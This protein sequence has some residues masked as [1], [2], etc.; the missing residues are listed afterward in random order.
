MEKKYTLA[1]LKKM[2][3]SFFLNFIDKIKENLKKDK[4]MKK[5]F[6]DYGVDLAELDFYPMKFGQIDTSAKTDHGVII[7]NYKLLTDGD[8]EKCCGYA[9]HEVTHVLQQTT[10]KKPTKSSDDGEY[11]ENKYEQEAFQNQVS[12]LADEFGEDEAED[13]VDHLLDYH[14]VENHKYDDL[15]DTL[16]EKVAA[17]LIRTK[18]EAFNTLEMSPT[19]NV[20]NIKTQ[21][22]L[23]AKKNHPDI[24]KDDGLKMKLINAAYEFLINYQ[25][26]LL[27][28]NE[29]AEVEET[30][31]T[32]GSDFYQDPSYEDISNYRDRIGRD[33]FDQKHPGWINE[34]KR[35]MGLDEYNSIFE[36]YEPSDDSSDQYHEEKE[37]YLDE[38]LAYIISDYLDSLQEGIDS[39]N[40]EQLEITI[41]HFREMSNSPLNL[42]NLISSVPNLLPY[43]KNKKNISYAWRTQL[44]GSIRRLMKSLKEIGSLR[45]LLKSPDLSL[46]IWAAQI[47]NHEEL[48]TLLNDQDLTIQQ[49]VFD[50]LLYEFQDL[51]HAIEVAKKATHNK[52]SFISKLQRHLPYEELKSKLN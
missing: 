50:R 12:Y 38:D 28:P 39:D 8:F 14:D 40:P 34:L 35:E 52:R 17:S 10:G 41:E 30:V 16:L 18:K 25:G 21:Y 44:E 37:R 3:P 7:F 47:A 32:T 9:I 4:S 42:D 48:L 51:D 13:Y 46:R 26:D 19:A 22:K 33:A 15:K 1:E 43:K 31:E 2:P 27:D 5:V 6:K 11:L 36:H 45:A 29:I 20:E 49:V 23:L 24:L